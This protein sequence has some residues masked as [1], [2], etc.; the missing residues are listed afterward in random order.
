MGI[1]QTE[2]LERSTVFRVRKYYNFLSSSN[3]FKFHIFHLDYVY[4]NSPAICNIKLH[5]LTT[6]V[7]V[8]MNTYVLLFPYELQR[9]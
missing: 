4:K 1:D 7:L 9:N 5:F 2:N 8:I 3:D 6:D